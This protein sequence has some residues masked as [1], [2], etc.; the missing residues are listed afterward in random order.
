MHPLVRRHG[1]QQLS[2]SFHRQLRALQTA[3]LDYK[4]I[5]DHASTHEANAQA[6]NMPSAQPHK[7]GQ[8]Y[9]DFRS[10]TAQVQA[11][12]TQLN[13]LSR[14][15]S[16]APTQQLREQAKQVK[17]NARA[18]D[19]RLAAVHRDMLHAALRLPN[20][21]HP[22]VPHGEPRVVKVVGSQHTEHPGWLRDHLDVALRLG[23]VDLQ[24]AARVAG[25]RF[26]FW[27]KAG[28]LLELALVQWAVGRA[29]QAGFTPH[30]T[31]DMARASVVDA[32]GFR[33][34]SSG[35]PEGG[36]EP[37]QTYRATPEALEAPADDPLCLVATAEIPLVAMR[38]GQEV[39]VPERLAGLSHCFRAE[40]GARGRDTRGVYRLHQFTKVELVVLARPD[41]SNTELDRLVDFQAALYA[42]LGLTFRVLDMPMHELGASAYRKYDVEAWMPGRRAWGEVSSASNCTDYQA[43][44]LGIRTRC[45]GELVFVHTLNATAVA[46]PRLIVAI[47]ES[48]QQE[49]GSVVVPEVLRPWMMGMDV[50]RPEDK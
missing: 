28:A 17:Q 30:V 49:D 46:V 41:E 18:L 36:G 8:L 7:V 44:R 21:A 37:S 38:L 26:V 39:H 1:T 24:A 5:R 15:L 23:I 40:A 48:F 42:D 31:P 3:S 16:C 13:T 34:R 47:L 14:Q 10:L 11:Q 33:P 29:V 27:R 22:E 19:A 50:L 2:H 35:S 32:C 20:L 12:R 45:Q 4:H 43:R 25:S 6:R 9:D